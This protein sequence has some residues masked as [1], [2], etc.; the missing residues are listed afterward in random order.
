MAQLKD[1][2]VTGASRLIG[3]AYTNTIQ[4]TSLKAPTSAGGS[5]YGTGTNGQVLLSNGSSIYWGSAAPTVTESTVSGWGFT[6]NTGTITGATT[7]GGLKVTGTTLGHSNATITAKTTAGVYPV[8]IDALGHITEAGTAIVSSA[9]ASGGA[10][11]SLVTTGEKYTW[12]NKSN[13]A[14]GTSAT[15]AAA[16][17]HT[18]TTSLAADSGTATVTLAHNTTYK[19][20]AGGTNVI[21]KTPTIPTAV[22]SFTNDSGYITS[23]DIP[24]QLFE[25]GT[26]SD[27]IQSIN[28][29]SDSYPATASGAGS[30]ALSSGIASGQGAVA[31]GMVNGGIQPTASGNCSFSMG[32]ST[33]ASA[34]YSMSVGQKT[35]ASGRIS[36]AFGNYTIASGRASMSVGQY[37]IEDTDDGTNYSSF[38][39]GA[40]KYIFTIGN[41][42]SDDARSNALTVDWN[43]NTEISGY[44][45]TNKI[46]A[47]TIAGGST[48][49]SGS[50]GQV[51]TS[52]GTHTYWGVELNGY[53]GSLATNGWKNLGGRTSGKRLTVSYNN[54]AAT[55]NA[56]TYSASLLF[57]CNDTKG[58]L[59]IAHASPVVSFAGGSVGGTTDNGPKWYY[60]LSGTSGCTYTLPTAT[61]TL[62]ASDGSNATG[63]WTLNLKTNNI[64]APTAAG[65]S[66]YGAGSSGQALM[67][68]GSTVYW[69]NVASSDAYVNKAGDTMTG[70]LINSF[71][72]NS[73]ARH[74]ENV[75]FYENNSSSYTGTIKIKLPNTTSNNVMLTARIIIFD[76]NAN[77]G[78]ELLVS[79]YTYNDGKWYQGAANPLGTFTKGVRLAYDGTNY[80]ILLGT[81]SSTWNYSKIILADIYSGYTLQPSTGYSI[82]LITSESG[83]TVTT[84]TTKLQADKVWGAVYNDYAEYR[85][86]KETIEPGR[87]I[88]EVGDGKLV[89]ANERLMRGCEI[90]SDTFGFAIG[91]SERCETPTAVSGRVLAFPY[92]D[93]E[94]FKNH[95]GWPVCSAPNGT[96]SIMTEEEE[97]KYPSRIIGT[98]SEIPSYE[99]WGSDNTKVNGRV[100]IKVR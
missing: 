15:T 91:K 30:F 53:D 60:K 32:L 94:E 49:G 3:D 12:N 18:H 17:N 87:V 42:T 71:N 24:E 20:T 80:C 56:G 38:G 86:T 81:T 78:C 16:G 75:A 6:K 33:I 82:S 50:A 83:Y 54:A 58:L 63:T 7:N 97:M 66:T 1:L 8:K 69:G 67:S 47:P 73:T 70:P 31:I 51:L 40:K 61:K 25:R 79:G 46:Q 48:Y 14:I 92:E 13:L 22:S 11:L 65:G 100:W 29:P 19:L 89:L 88:T 21:F 85:E 74:F 99:V 39:T 64:Q 43:G 72:S 36:Q 62:A 27:S 96:V 41:G 23:S 59:D 5:T 4:I 10:T 28:P 26:G 84:L 2:L 34:N 37:N 45:K 9:A 68:N 76:Y 44:L 52:D 35:L 57:G 90:V 95:I 93:L 55:W 98:I 77:S